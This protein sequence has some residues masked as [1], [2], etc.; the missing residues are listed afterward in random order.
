MLLARSICRPFSLQGASLSGGRFLCSILGFIHYLPV[1]ISDS[2]T[3]I[4]DCPSKHRSTM[5]T[6]HRLEAYATLSRRVA[7]SGCAAIAPGMALRD[8]PIVRKT[9]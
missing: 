3:T 5:A 1:G 9:T 4:I 8:R 6:E 7:T 2:P